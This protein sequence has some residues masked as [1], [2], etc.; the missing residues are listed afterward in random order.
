MSLIGLPI[1][2]MKSVDVSLEDVFL[3]VT[4]GAKEAAKNAGS[5]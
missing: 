2:M 3:Q 5:I 1:L 4:E